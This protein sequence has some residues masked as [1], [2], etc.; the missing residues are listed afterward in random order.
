MASNLWIMRYC[1]PLEAGSWTACPIDLIQQSNSCLSGASGENLWS[2]LGTTCCV[3]WPSSGWA[4]LKTLRLGTGVS[5]WLKPSLLLFYRKWRGFLKEG[6]K[7]L[8]VCL[9]CKLEQTLGR[10]SCKYQRNI[11]LPHYLVSV[12]FKSETNANAKLSNKNT[13]LQ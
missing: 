13:V 8:P 11:Y 12:S 3:Y 2:Q 5:P 6:K 4:G 7:T 10:R 9:L 1:P